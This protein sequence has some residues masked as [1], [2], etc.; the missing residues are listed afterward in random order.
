[1]SYIDEEI[2]KLQ[3]I[4]ERKKYYNLDTGIYIDD[5]LTE[6]EKTYIEELDITI[7]LPTTFVTL[8]ESMKKIKYPVETRPALIKTSLDTSVNFTFSIM[9]VE[10]KKEQLPLALKQMKMIIQKLN[11]AN[12]CYEEKVEKTDYFFDIAYFDY[13]G[14]ALDARLYNIMYL[15]PLGDKKILHGGFNCNFDLKNEWSKVAILIIK[16]IVTGNKIG[17][18]E[19]D[20]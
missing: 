10:I 16:S 2:I 4:E 7:T 3:R 19:N 13:M 9:P 11:P 12:T 1:M 20:C 18:K 6:F 15:T 17:G 8:P 5:V 14:H